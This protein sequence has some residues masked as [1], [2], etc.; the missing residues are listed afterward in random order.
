[1]TQ[2]PPSSDPNNDEQT[3]PPARRGGFLGWLLA[4]SIV[5]IVF[6]IANQPGGGV[7]GGAGG[8]CYQLIEQRQTFG[9]CTL[10]LH[11]K[12]V[13]GHN[14]LGCNICERRG[15]IVPARACLHE[16]YLAIQ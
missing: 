6:S 2:Q 13:A 14:R 1:M 3:Q 10:C 8:S 15:L 4:F 16:Y 11:R 5:A 7:D 9:I 12:G